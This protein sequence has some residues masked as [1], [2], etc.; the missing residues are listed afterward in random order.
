[1][2][3]ECLTAG[4]DTFTANAYLVR[5]SE[6][7]LVDVGAMDGIADVVGS[8]VDTLHSVA[9]T[10]QHGDHVANLEEIIGTFD[11]E[12]AA[13]EPVRPETD[14]LEDGEEV[15][16]GGQPF[17]AIHTPGHAEDHLVFVGGSVL[18]SGDVVV[19][20]D[21]AFED[22]SFGRTDI[23]GADR[24]TLIGSLET[25]LDRLPAGVD[26]LYAGHGDPFEGDVEVVISRALARA[27]RREPKYPDQA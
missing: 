20:N 18:F 9:I 2:D 1:M 26:T 3:V 24:E 19:Y 12:V 13:F 5:G 8:R 14:E 10:H 27:E 16:I 6:N 23:P 7:T 11:P 17:E 25:L 15:E 4:A 21:A 22:G